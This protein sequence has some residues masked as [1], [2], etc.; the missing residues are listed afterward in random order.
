MDGEKRFLGDRMSR[1][2]WKRRRG[3]YRK[4][5]TLLGRMEVFEGRLSNVQLF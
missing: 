4:F 1:M 2:A 5:Y 3:Q